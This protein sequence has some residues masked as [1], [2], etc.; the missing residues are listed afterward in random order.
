MINKVNSVMQ[1][2]KLFSSIVLHISFVLMICLYG[3]DILFEVFR[4]CSIQILGFWIIL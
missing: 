3:S 1:V 4:G 2:F